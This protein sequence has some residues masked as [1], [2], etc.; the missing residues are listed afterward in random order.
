MN[1]KIL[2]VDDERAIR[3]IL[4][5]YLES[6]GYSC[7]EAEG[8]SSAKKMLAGGSYDLLLSD[9]KMPDGS[10]LEL[11]RYAKA[12]YPQMGRIVI[13]A[14]GDAETSSDII[15]IGVLGYIIK[16][17][18]RDVVLVTVKNSMHLL[19][20]NLHLQAYKAELEKKLSERTEKLT[21]IMNNL[22]V[23]LVLL[24]REMHILE[25]NNKMRQFFP[26]AARGIKK[27]CY[28]VLKQSVCEKC[29]VGE[30]MDTGRTV[31]KV[32]RFET[33]LGERDFRILASP[34]LDGAGVIYAGLCLYEDITEKL[35]LERDLR[36]AQKMEAVGQLAAG[37]AHEINTPMQYVGDNIRFFRDSFGDIQRIL[38]SC[39]LWRDANAK[40]APTEEAVRQLTDDINSNDIPFLLEEIPTALTQSFEGASRVEKIVRAMKDFSH[41]GNDEKVAMDINKLLEST[42]TVS[43]NEWKY[44]ADMKIDLAGDLPLVTCFAGELSQAFLNIIV[45]GA[46][47]IG[48]VIASGS[49]GKGKIGIT[50]SRKG[51]GVEIQISDSGGGIPEEIQGR[52]FEQFF[53]TKARGKGTGQGLAIAHRV[54]VDIHQ[55]TLSFTSEKGRGTVFTIFLPQNSP[56]GPALES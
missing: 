16:P 33:A 30:A 6:A 51:E 19:S 20:L 25:L 54:I 43:R 35:I 46:H 26:D 2:I 48:D 27:P 36:Q 22:N 39:L 5:R 9:L 41:P 12:H 17:V 28:S 52:I 38:N 18:T 4:V 47:A 29:S 21:A 13:S 31:E 42:I 3:K 32:E 55:G 14:F 56:S 8:E 50:T 23:G 53:T 37:I 44:V 7:Q 15:D 40:G 11:I 45:N 34:V 24:D 10:G 1:D 49:T